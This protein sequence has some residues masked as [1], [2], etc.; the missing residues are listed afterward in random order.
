MAT[1]AAA[2]MAIRVLLDH[3]VPEENILLVSL[4]MA[5]SGKVSFRP[6]L[7]DHLQY[8][9][10][11]EGLGECRIYCGGVTAIKEYLIGVTETPATFSMYIAKMKH[12]GCDQIASCTCV[13]CVNQPAAR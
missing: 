8:L 3:D 4:I 6:T 12:I 5:V 7:I 11:S 1:G 9:T 13:I 10:S 2:M